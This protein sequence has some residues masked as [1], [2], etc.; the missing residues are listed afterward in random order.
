MTGNQAVFFAICWS[1]VNSDIDHLVIILWRWYYFL[2]ERDKTT[3]IMGR[4]RGEYSNRSWWWYHNVVGALWPFALCLS[5]IVLSLLSSFGGPPKNDRTSLPAAPSSTANASAMGQPSGREQTFSQTFTTLNRD[6]Q[7]AQTGRERSNSRPM[8]MAHGH[9]PTLMEIAQDTLPEFLPIFTHL[10]NHQ[11]KLYQ[12]G[13]F[14]K[15][16]DLDNRMWTNEYHPVSQVIL[17]LTYYCFRGSTIR[18]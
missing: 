11:N 16:N 7:L 5:S 6:S 2:I 12:E 10:N 17:Y 13:F 9:G 8:S 14:L 3:G 18:R 4:S 15:L 1:R